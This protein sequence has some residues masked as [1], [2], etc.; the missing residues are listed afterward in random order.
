MSLAA[1][2]QIGAFNECPRNAIKSV[3][4]SRDR[5]DE[6]H[7][8]CP[9]Y[10]ENMVFY[11]EFEKDVS[12]L[13]NNQIKIFYE[14]ELDVKSIAA[15]YIVQIPP[16]CRILK[17]GIDGLQKRIKKSTESEST[18]IFQS[19]VVLKEWSLTYGF[20]F[21]TS[22]WIL[23]WNQ[24]QRNKVWQHTDVTVGAIL[25]KGNHRY[26][27][28]YSNWTLWNTRS[29]IA[30]R[31]VGQVPSVCIL[32][33]DSCHVETY[34]WKSK[35]FTFWGTWWVMFIWCYWSFFMVTT[36]QLLNFGFVLFGWKLFEAI[37]AIPMLPVI[38]VVPLWIINWVVMIYATSLTHR[39]P[40]MLGLSLFVNF[41]I[42]LF[43]FYLFA[44]RTTQPMKTLEIK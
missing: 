14:S 43:P 34:L 32:K 41:Y 31:L 7:I 5:F 24:W 15:N 37:E 38:L 30:P 11:D 20:L 4:E 19:L 12:V 2:I 44:V 8:I 39:F 35:Y 13:E 26:I 33:G 18:F 6:L 40:R 21:V 1:V 27:P 23:F 25:Q 28:S 42:I 10:M 16:N 9:H 22:L 29:H 3:I 36:A 17:S